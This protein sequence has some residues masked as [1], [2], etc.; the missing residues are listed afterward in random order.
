MKPGDLIAQNFDFTLVA[1]SYIVSVLGSYVA[2]ECAVRIPKP[3]GGTRFGYVVCAAVALGGVAIWSMHFVGMTALQLPIELAYN[4]ILTL[5][6]LV[7]AVLVAALAFWFMGRSEFTWGNLFI[8][9]PITGIGV[10]VMHYLGMGAMRMQAEIAWN[11]GIVALSVVIAIVA[12]TV[13][14]W[15][16][17]TLRT[18]VLRVVAA[19]VMGVAVCGM[20]YTGM[21]AGNFVCTASSTLSANDFGG[22]DLPYMIVTLAIIVLGGIVIHMI[23]N[24]QVEETSVTT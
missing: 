18:V 24:W 8:S 7:A 19:F 6:S 4:A 3:G 15:L 2:L 5:V 20:H 16:A 14:L 12:A 23:L 22:A 21:V 17:F 13:A 1:L 9:G 10:A 11:Q